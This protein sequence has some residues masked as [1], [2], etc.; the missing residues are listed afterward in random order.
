MSLVVIDGNEFEIGIIKITR[1]ASF[2]QESLGVTMDLKKHYDVK[3]TYY[4][5]D[6]EFFTKNM[7]VVD[8]DNL[9]EL[10]TLPQESHTVT[11]PYG[12]ST[13]TFEAKVTVA[14]DDLLFKYTPKTKWGGI[15]VTFEA[16]EPQKEA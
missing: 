13:I 11:L 6:V 5:Y 1:R 15:K 7:N 4:D 8:Y 9:Y 2:S 14:Q 16:L 12:Q 10:L 3:G